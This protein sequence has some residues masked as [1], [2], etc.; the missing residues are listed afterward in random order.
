MLAI[1]GPLQF[2]EIGYEENTAIDA[3]TEWGTYK[4]QSHNQRGNNVITS[5]QVEKK[6]ITNSR[7]R[8]C[9]KGK[10]RHSAIAHE[11]ACNLQISHAQKP[12]VRH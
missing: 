6:L 9:P 10:A 5:H 12:R 11:G 7:E 4:S 8:N 3:W 1:F 2:R